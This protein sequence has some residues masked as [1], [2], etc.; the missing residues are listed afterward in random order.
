MMDSP[1]SHPVTRTVVP[2]NA[3]V[4]RRALPSR[5]M[6]NCHRQTLIG[7]ICS[8]HITTPRMSFPG[9]DG[10][11]W[12]VYLSLI[13]ILPLLL[14]SLQSAV[15]ATV[16]LFQ[17]DPIYDIQTVRAVWT[18][19]LSGQLRWFAGTLYGRLFIEHRGNCVLPHDS[20]VLS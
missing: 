15:C 7:R 17:G 3:I 10:T 4:C 16:D 8:G 9:S 2:R 1:R 11:R 6:R 13:V 14:L 12:N 20:T 5:T 18:D 19:G